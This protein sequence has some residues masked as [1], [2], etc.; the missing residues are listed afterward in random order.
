[1]LNVQCSTSTFSEKIGNTI[2][3]GQRSESEY[4][5]ETEKKVI[6]FS[7]FCKKKGKNLTCMYCAGLRAVYGC[8]Y[9]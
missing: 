7:H 2:L 9:D 6:F 3:C 1:M 4:L 5:R 8:I